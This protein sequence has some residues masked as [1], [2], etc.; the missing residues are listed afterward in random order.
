MTYPLTCTYCGTELGQADNYDHGE[1]VDCPDCG[2]I[3]DLQREDAIH[4]L[5]VYE[6]PYCGTDNKRDRSIEDGDPPQVRCENDERVDGDDC[7]RLFDP[8]GALTTDVPDG[9]RLKMVPD[10]GGD[11]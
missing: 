1:I 6:C 5:V 8:T 10:N 2:V 7:G 4:D 9:S 11:A 3:Y